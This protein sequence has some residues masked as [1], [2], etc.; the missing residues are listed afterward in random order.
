MTAQP[1][2]LHRCCQQTGAGCRA[3]AQAWVIW[4]DPAIRIFARVDQAWMAAEDGGHIA[5][6]V[7]LLFE[8][9]GFAD[10]IMEVDS[11]GAVDLPVKALIWQADTAAA[12]RLRPLETY[13]LTS[14]ESGARY[15]D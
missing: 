9:V 12:V 4:P 8:N 11:Q 15:R 1:A 2:R 14:V 3:A 10:Q 6:V 5:S 7:E 13:S